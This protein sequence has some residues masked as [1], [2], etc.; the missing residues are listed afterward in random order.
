MSPF[1]PAFGAAMYEREKIPRD[2]YPNIIRDQRYV[3]DNEQH[4]CFALALY[5]APIQETLHTFLALLP[6]VLALH[7][8]RERET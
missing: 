4:V 2:Y 1:Y 8:G 6:N 7:L 5:K 3:R